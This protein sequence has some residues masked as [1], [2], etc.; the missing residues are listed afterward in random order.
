MIKVEVANPP[1]KISE[2]RDG[3]MFTR[4]PIDNP[5]DSQV[6]IKHAYDRSAKCYPCTCWG[7]V[8]KEIFLK[9]TADVYTEYTF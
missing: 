6:Y 9:S 2:L 1:R 8:N 3:E 5:K 4:K 7:D